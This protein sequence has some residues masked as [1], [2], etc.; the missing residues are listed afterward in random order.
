MLSYI[1]SDLMMQ[2]RRANGEEPW[3]EYFNRLLSYL[4]DVLQPWPRNHASDLQS[5]KSIHI[6]LGIAVSEAFSSVRV[7][8]GERVYMPFRTLIGI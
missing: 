8:K 6:H 2:R 3:E 4:Y 1:I 5:L 7:R